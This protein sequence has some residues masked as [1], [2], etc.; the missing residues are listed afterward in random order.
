MIT[1]EEILCGSKDEILEYFNNTFDIISNLIEYGDN[2][3]ETYM[4]INDV[5]NIET[6]INQIMKKNSP[7]LIFIYNVRPSFSNTIETN[8]TISKFWV[9]VRTPRTNDALAS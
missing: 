8:L 9:F 6:Q 7:G 2:V 1:K 3:K 5:G 4:I